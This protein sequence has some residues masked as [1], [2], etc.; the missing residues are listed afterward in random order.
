MRRTQI[1]AAVLVGPSESE[2]QKRLQLGALG[3]HIGRV[4][5]RAYP[6][7]GDDL[8]I[9]DIDRRVDSV[10]SADSVEKSLLRGGAL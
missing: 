4:K 1:L 2:R 10:A 9:K 7:V 8:A 3:V 6:F 5:E